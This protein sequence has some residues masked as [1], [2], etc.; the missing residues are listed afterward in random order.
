LGPQ[1]VHISGAARER[2]ALSLNARSMIA[3]PRSQSEKFL[4]EMRR[5]TKNAEELRSG[6]IPEE[7]D[8]VSRDFLKSLDKTASDEFKK[9]RYPLMADSE[10]QQAKVAE[11]MYR[12]ND[13]V[14][15]YQQTRAEKYRKAAQEPWAPVG[16]D[17]PFEQAVPQ[18]KTA[19]P[20]QS[21]QP[22]KVLS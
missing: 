21:Y 17:P 7:L 1:A 3:L 9:H 18:S 22:P 6:R 5:R 8:E 4:V 13:R 11:D 10:E 16:P 12:T 19:A 2:H 20:G 14:A 15:N